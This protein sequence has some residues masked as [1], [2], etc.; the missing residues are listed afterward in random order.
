MESAARSAAV[1]LRSILSDIRLSEMVHKN[2]QAVVVIL[3][4]ALH[5]LSIATLCE[6][7]IKVF[8]VTFATWSITSRRKRVPGASARKSQS[9]AARMP[10]SVLR[11]VCFC[12][13]VLSAT[14]ASTTMPSMLHHQLP[15]W[16]PLATSLPRHPIRLSILS[17]SLGLHQ[18]S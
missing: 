13:P 6:A 15:A 8:H 18:A 7:V 11:Q 4:C 16:F 10:T 5:V 3:T 9:Q 14:S 12:H 1:I 17:Q 2:L